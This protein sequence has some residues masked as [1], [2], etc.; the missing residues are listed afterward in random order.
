MAD[1]LLCIGWA[2]CMMA[3]AAGTLI[4]SGLAVMAGQEEPPKKAEGRAYLV[5]WAASVIA[6]VV[7]GQVFP[8]V[9]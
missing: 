9:N 4:G 7:L 2:I 6:L 3:C 1:T 5:L 8:G